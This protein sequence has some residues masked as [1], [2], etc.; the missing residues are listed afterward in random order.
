MEL[1][2]WRH[3]EAEEGEPDLARKLT[4]RGKKQ[5][6]RAAEWLDRH[7]PDRTRILVSPAMRAQQ[8]AAALAEISHRKLRTV[9][10]IAPDAAA[11]DV[12]EATDWPDAKFPVLVVGHQ[13][14]L[15]Q[16]A[17][18]LLAGEIQDWSITQGRAVV[19]E[20]RERDGDAQV[21]LRAV[22]VPRRL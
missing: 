21:V 4:P 9:D 8:T 18:L 1:I 7:L 19:D 11:R 15:G 17:S 6:R 20:F 10:A 2:L 22:S 3:A 13:P 16:V 5:A 14:T 12:L